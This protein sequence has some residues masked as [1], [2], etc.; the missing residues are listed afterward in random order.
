MTFKRGIN[1]SL[2]TIGCLI[3][4]IFRTIKSFTMKWSDLDLYH[5]VKN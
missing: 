5:K 1:T 2:R 4:E 3:F